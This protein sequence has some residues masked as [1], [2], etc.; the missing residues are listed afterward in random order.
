VWWPFLV[1]AGSEDVRQLVLQGLER[2][3]HTGVDDK[4]SDFHLV[5]AP[6]L[7]QGRMQAGIDD[8]SH[9]RLALCSRDGVAGLLE[10]GQPV[11]AVCHHPES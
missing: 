6:R 8:D 5:L 4:R 2:L 7:A 1:F 10:L 11:I 3:F 9:L